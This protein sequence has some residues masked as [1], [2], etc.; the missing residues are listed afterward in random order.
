MS[1]DWIEVVITKQDLLSEKYCESILPALKSK[2]VPVRGNFFLELP[3]N[4]EYKK[5][6]CPITG[7]TDFIYRITE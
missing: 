1:K 7:N 5:I 3:E 4:M 2:G 6:T